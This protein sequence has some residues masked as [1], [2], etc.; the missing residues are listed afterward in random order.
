M[1]ILALGVLATSCSEPTAA[2]A[3]ASRTCDRLVGATPIVALGIVS[4]AVSEVQDDGGTGLE[5]RDEMRAQCPGI[6]DQLDEI[7]PGFNSAFEE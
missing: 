4:T 5:L 3:V 2:E 1:I 6:M 7:S